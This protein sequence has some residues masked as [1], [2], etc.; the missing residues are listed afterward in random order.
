[1]TKET[2]ELLPSE[3]KSVFGGV[4][5]LALPLVVFTDAFQDAVKEI[6]KK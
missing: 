2:R 4:N 3:I 6:E 5:P 1:M